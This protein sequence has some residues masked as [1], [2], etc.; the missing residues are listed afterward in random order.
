MFRFSPRSNRACRVRWREWGPEAFREARE[1]GRPLALFLVAWWCGFC[2]RMDEA[3]LS[4]P[5]AIAL[6][7]AFFVP[8]RVE[9]SRRPDVDLRYNR[10]G[11]PTI[12]FL[13]PQGR[14]F[15]SVNY[16]DAGP[17]ADLLARIVQLHRDGQLPPGVEPLQTGG[18]PAP[19]GAQPPGP[20]L[21]YEI[22]G[23]M[24]GLADPVHGGFGGGFKFLHAEANDFFLYLYEA[25]GERRYLDHALLTLA[26]LRESP[27]RDGEL[28]GFFRYS[29]RPDWS[30]PHW[31]K[32]L[33]DQA[34]LLRNY[35][36]AWRL[37][38]DAACRESAGELLRFV[39]TCLYD[40]AAGLFRGG[41]DYAAIDGPPAPGGAAPTLPV[42]DETLYCDANA[43]MASAALDA[44]R[45]L[46]RE[47]WRRMAA[48][49]LEA[50]WRRFRA[51][52]GRTLHWWDG[53]P[54]GGA[55][56]P[57]LL[58]D[59]VETGLA[60]LDAH[61]ALGGEVY[62]RRAAG[63]AETI[64][65]RNGMPG[66][67]FA[68]IDEPGPGRLATPLAVMPRNAR[69]ALFLLRLA[70]AAGNGAW[71]QAAF[72]ALAAFPEPHREHGAFAAGYG[73]AL[74][75]LLETTGVTRLPA[76]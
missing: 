70:E 34:G 60:L 5:D 1:S 61:A 10:D 18:A 27:M 4:D 35:L 11:W 75:K 8:A 58:A 3:A 59:A 66:G 25:S 67:A 68:D 62:L 55:R 15:H 20:A 22:V 56:V 16:M 46:G 53:S 13:T 41:Q 54:E 32:L 49:A 63:L 2:Q 9:E 26:R 36:H 30:E 14:H 73:L 44:W 51:G 7:N 21:F 52:D 69:A 71:R 43:L 40:P 74:G 24:E 23:M 57:G 12:A 42:V 64:M 48:G 31:E 33:Q 6:L 39:E 19:K 28:G 17:F 72:R 45:V 37:S 76:C 29:S 47:R 38:G 65:G 50:L